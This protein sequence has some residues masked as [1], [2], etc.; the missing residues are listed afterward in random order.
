MKTS[1]SV[2][3]RLS[4]GLLSPTQLFKYETSEGLTLITL[5]PPAK[6][7][8]NLFFHTSVVVIFYSLIR[9]QDIYSSPSIKTKN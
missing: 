5:L 1:Q 6:Q 7:S 9:L 4:K 2:M 8:P 3:K